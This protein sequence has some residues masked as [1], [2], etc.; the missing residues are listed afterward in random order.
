MTPP[1]A[2]DAAIERA[3]AELNELYQRPDFWAPHEYGERNNLTFHADRLQ[4]L[5]DALRA[6]H[7]DKVPASLAGFVLP[8][9]DDPLPGLLAALESAN[10]A[11]A[12]ITAFE[13]DARE[14][15][16]NTNFEIV[17]MEREKVRAAL[18][19]ARAIAAQGGGK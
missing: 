10:N 13:M 18:S 4:A 14:I 19:V 3:C 15:M 7:G 2:S 6:E 1:K 11:L 5:S 8:V 12:Q 9:G 17:K 16:G